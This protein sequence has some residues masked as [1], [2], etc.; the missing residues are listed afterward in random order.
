MNTMKSYLQ[1][2]QE[3]THKINLEVTNEPLEIW[4]PPEKITRRLN[5]RKNLF[6]LKNLKSFLKTSPDPTKTLSL[7]V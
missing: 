5:K 3:Y 4:S 7:P 6:W 2:T 1:L